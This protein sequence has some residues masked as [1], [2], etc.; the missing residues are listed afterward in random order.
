M[1]IETIITFE[2]AGDAARWL[3]RYTTSPSNKVYDLLLC[4]FPHNKETDVESHKIA[5]A[6]V[7]YLM[8]YY[9]IKED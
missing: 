8:K 4:E 7:K 5:K 6:A 2:D 1:R 3:A 9:Q